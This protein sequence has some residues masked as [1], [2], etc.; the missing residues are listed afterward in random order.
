MRAYVTPERRQRL[1]WLFW[2]FAALG[3]PVMASAWSWY[4]MAYFEEMT[5]QSKALAAGTT[6]EG[7]G[8]MMG[9]PPVVLAHLIG[10][11]V[12]GVIATRRASTELR[13]LFMA[14][15][16]VALTSLIGIGVAQ[17]LWDGDLF[18]MGANMRPE[19]IP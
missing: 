14:V 12:L 8:A 9:V 11:I 2:L 16:V 15:A 7:L 10:L 13:G 6:M 17:L 3:V 1:G 18:G 5:E 4:G 19:Y